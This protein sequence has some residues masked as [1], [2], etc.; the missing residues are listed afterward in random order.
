MLCYIEWIVDVLQVWDPFVGLSVRNFESGKSAPV[1]SL[2]AMP[3]PHTSLLTTT[4]DG[5]V[6]YQP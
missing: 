1:T 2:E 5:Y 3:T 4:S 6:R